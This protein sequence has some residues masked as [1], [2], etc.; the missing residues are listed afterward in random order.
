MSSSSGILLVGGSGFIGR[1]LAASF[2][3]EGREVHV[4]SRKP[5]LDLPTGVQAHVG[6]QG[7]KAVLN[8]LLARCA[9]VI[10]LASATTP[11][12]TVWSPSAEAEASLLPAL[13]FL[14]CL[15]NFPESRVILCRPGERFTA[16]RKAQ[17][18]LPFRCQGRTTAPA[19]WRS[20]PSSPFS[21][22]VVRAG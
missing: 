7:D 21:A 15:Q 13:R 22:S 9:Q 20:K 3:I 19:K 17:M 18:K 4:L 6:D 16:M 2:A 8:P 12:D 11:G 10:H 5:A 1:A 14:E